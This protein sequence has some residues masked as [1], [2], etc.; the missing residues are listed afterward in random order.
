MRRGV[1][2]ACGPSFLFI[3]PW[4]ESLSTHELACTTACAHTRTRGWAGKGLGRTYVRSEK[5][6]P[7][8]LFYTVCVSTPICAALDQ[9]EK[10][11]FSFFFLLFS[12]FSFFLSSF[13]PPLSSPRERRSRRI[14]F[15]LNPLAHYA[16]RE[17][18]PLASSLSEPSPWIARL[19]RR[20]SSAGF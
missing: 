19:F 2:A 18:W 15:Q 9:A 5:A 17:Q 20:S 16:P 1:T 12:P 11:P 14:N 13:F 10:R 7:N 6:K 8:L 3:R 4:L